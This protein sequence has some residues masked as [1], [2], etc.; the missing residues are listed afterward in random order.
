MFN[1]YLKSTYFRIPTARPIS[2]F[3][4]LTKEVN[5]SNTD[6]TDP[7]WLNICRHSYYCDLIDSIDTKEEC[8]ET[9]L[10]ELWGYD[11]NYS[12]ITTDDIL[13]KAQL[14]HNS[15]GLLG[16]LPV[17]GDLKIS[18]SD[19]VLAGFVV[20]SCITLP[21]DRIGRGYTLHVQLTG[22]LIV[23]RVNRVYRVNM[24]SA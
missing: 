6:D 5:C 22:S 2:G 18:C 3:K 23:H 12:A 10:L 11:F 24:K 7:D 14:I 17:Y 4:S 8:L 15:L 13:A 19:G 20:I 1:L 16:A 9:G 21:R